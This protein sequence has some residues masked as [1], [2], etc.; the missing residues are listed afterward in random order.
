VRRKRDEAGHP[1]LSGAG[2]KSG[3]EGQCFTGLAGRCDQRP[4]TSSI[5]LRFVVFLASGDG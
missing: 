4:S 2:V 5:L 3:A 1:G